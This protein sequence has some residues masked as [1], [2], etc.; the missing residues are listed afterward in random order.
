M[1]RALLKNLFRPRSREVS[2]SPPDRG[3]PL[4]LHIG[5]QE[6]HPDWKVVN[7]TPGPFTDYA[8][9]CT[10]LS[11]FGDGTVAQIY[12]S[13]VIEHLRYQRE[14]GAALREFNR[15]L[16]PGGTLHVS[17]PDLATLC[18]LFLDPSL[19]GKS[20]FH[21]MRMMYGGQVDDADFH[22]VGLTDEFLKEYLHKAGFTDIE[23]VAD[24]GL[25]ND[26]SR[27]EFAGRRISLN[28]VARKPRPTRDGGAHTAD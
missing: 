28:L 2:V 25:F 17:V 26:T 27:L 13:H 1:L 12:A 24:L 4:R 16:E 18:A 15:V 5:G 19:D 21:V 14:L 22:Y 7:V 3:L 8:R 9:S 23:R 20:R 10:D 11:I 6:P